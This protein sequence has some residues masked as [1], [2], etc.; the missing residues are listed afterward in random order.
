ME[1]QLERE[2]LDSTR[3]NRDQETD[4]KAHDR[5]SNRG[6]SIGGVP[7]Q[8]YEAVD[9]STVVIPRGKPKSGKFWKTVRS[10]RHSNIKKDKPL[11]TTWNK[12]MQQRAERQSIK[13]F[14]KELKELKRQQQEIK[15][16]AKIKRMKKKQLRQI[17]KRDT[18]NTG[19][20]VNEDDCS[21][22]EVPVV[23]LRAT[24]T[25]LITPFFGYR[26][27]LMRNAI[28]TINVKIPQGRLSAARDR[29]MRCRLKFD[30]L[31]TGVNR[32]ACCHRAAF[33]KTKIALCSCNSL[34]RSRQRHGQGPNRVMGSTNRTVSA[35]NGD[36]RGKSKLKSFDVGVNTE[37][38]SIT[39]INI[40][41]TRPIKDVNLFSL[42]KTVALAL[43]DITVLAANTAQV[44]FV[45][46]NY[47]EEDL[48]VYRFTMVML[49]LSIIL[50]VA[51]AAVLLYMATFNIERDNVYET[52]GR[53]A[54]ITNDIIASLVL[55]ITIVNVL[56]AVFGCE[57]KAWP[58]WSLFGHV[59]RMPLDSPPQKVLSVAFSKKLKPRLGRPREGLLSSL[60]NFISTITS[61]SS[62]TY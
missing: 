51:T 52:I 34:F 5:P 2:G 8:T 22:A 35:L 49:G 36:F 19:R 56:V 38:S 43:F 7:A 45:R 57:P 16:T 32:P 47:N 15:N 53:K 10:E 46:H 37:E 29:P 54:H 26:N 3:E 30:F 60:V 48:G 20:I 44:K 59:L 40:L 55:V 25:Y 42:K 62:L 24:V 17:Q 13:S 6:G 1:V 31:I 39:V 27:S 41:A 33:G 18:G 50:L 14:E 4:R 61:D 12:K 21:A 11:R 28:H 58:S 9:G 23:E